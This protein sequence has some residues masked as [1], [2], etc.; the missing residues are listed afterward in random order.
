MDRFFVD[1][2]GK[3]QQGGKKQTRRHGKK[4]GKHSRHNRRS[5]KSMQNRKKQKGG[6]GYQ[7]FGS[8]VENSRG[9]SFDLN[10]RIGGQ[11]ERVSYSTCSK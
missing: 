2:C 3:T 4:Y 7:Q 10:S 5:R 6:S 1:S 9:F 11:P 8:N